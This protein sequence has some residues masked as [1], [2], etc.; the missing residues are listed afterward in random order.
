MPIE[1]TV[2]PIKIEL[3]NVK[4]AAFASE[5]TECFSAVVYLDGVKA[6]EARNEG[7]GGCTFLHDITEGSIAH[8]NAY[9][10]SLG[11]KVT[12]YEAF[13]DKP[14]AS[15]KWEM[16]QDAESLIDD[17]LAEWLTFRDCKR[18]ISKKL[19]FVCPGEKG[20]FSYPAK[21]KDTP[22]LRAHLAKKHPTAIILTGLPDAEAV[23][24]W[25]EYAS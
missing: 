20:I 8:L 24:L 7:R 15:G 17:A 2:Q 3:R 9:G 12:Q 16:E 11:P 25:K 14:T 21:Y 22:E 23:R 6:I 1:T 13:E 18:A 4:H 10:A 19:T 5:E